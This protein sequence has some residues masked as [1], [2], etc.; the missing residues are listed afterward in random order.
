MTLQYLQHVPIFQKPLCFQL[1][2]DYVKD[3]GC[4]GQDVVGY[5]W[6]PTNSGGIRIVCLLKSWLS[7]DY[8]Y[9]GSMMNVFN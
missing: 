7:G 8:V 2:E 1:F 9:D 3:V 4:R 5:S 6:Y